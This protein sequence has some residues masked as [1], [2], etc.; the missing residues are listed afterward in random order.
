M[1]LKEGRA[2][3]RAMPSLD[4]LMETFE[5]FASAQNSNYSE[6]SSK[7]NAQVHKTKERERDPLDLESY[8]YTPSKQIGNDRSYLIQHTTAP[9]NSVQ[10]EQQQKL[11]QNEYPKY[12]YSSSLLIDKNANEAL[13]RAANL[14]KNIA[15]SLN[16]IENAPILLDNHK[17]SIEYKNGA[18]SKNSTGSTLDNQSLKF[19]GDKVIEYFNRAPTNDTSKPITSPTAITTVAF[20]LKYP[21][22]EPQSNEYSTSRPLTI[23]SDGLIS[24]AYKKDTN[25]KENM[26]NAAALPMSTHNINSNQAVDYPTTLEDSLFLQIPKKHKFSDEFFRN[27]YNRMSLQYNGIIGPSIIFKSK[28]NDFNSINNSTSSSSSSSNNNKNNKYDYLS[29]YIVAPCK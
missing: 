1:R 15:K 28:E 27:R 6:P 25:E 22:T 17:N 4:N 13:K 19:N 23:Y 29:P 5:Y 8:L 21:L 2:L 7:L 10:Y 26:L 24:S 14:D 11:Q 20:D 9:V 16:N 12:T 3:S 18:K